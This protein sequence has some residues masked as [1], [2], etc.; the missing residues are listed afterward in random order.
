[1]NKS[2]QENGGNSFTMMSAFL[3]L[4]QQGNE[5][6]MEEFLQA[7]SLAALHDSTTTTTFRR[8]GDDRKFHKKPLSEVSSEK[9]QNLLAECFI[10][11]GG[12]K[13]GE[14]TSIED[15]TE[16]VRIAWP[17]LLQYSFVMVDEA[18]EITGVTTLVDET[19]MAKMS[20][21][22]WHPYLKE[23]YE[24]LDSLT[25]SVQHQLPQNPERG[26]Y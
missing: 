17:M 16:V 22:G 19:D 21:E 9:A 4:K 5:M 20:C 10:E 13:E 23:I 18:E 14:K 2:Y 11:K 8:Q 1:M 26:S 15:F 7:E 24:Y 25:V 12:M 3:R 6:S